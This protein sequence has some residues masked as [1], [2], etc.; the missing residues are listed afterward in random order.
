[1]RLLLEGGANPGLLDLAKRTP[2]AYAKQKLRR[3]WKEV[4]TLLESA[5]TGARD[6]AAFLLRS[7]CD[8]IWID[9]I[10]INQEDLLERNAQVT[11]MFRIYGSA[12]QA[13]V[14][15][16]IEDQEMSFVRGVVDHVSSDS[17]GPGPSP[18]QALQTLRELNFNNPAPHESPILSRKAIQWHAAESSE[19]TLWWGCQAKSVH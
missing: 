17:S 14:W 9:A 18:E 4:C 12:Q 8:L 19:W 11:L 15:L 3:Q 1:M 6:R 13:L 5:E 10:C 2:L 16:G 7:R